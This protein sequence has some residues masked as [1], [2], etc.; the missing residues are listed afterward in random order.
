MK[1]FQ[2]NNLKIKHDEQIANDSL[3]DNKYNVKN[4]KVKFFRLAK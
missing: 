3:N 2:F 4:D 1:L